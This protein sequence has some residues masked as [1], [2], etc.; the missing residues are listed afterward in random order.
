M[1]VGMVMVLRNWKLLPP[2]PVPGA[3]RE[4]G[5]TVLFER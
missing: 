2:K 3:T 1:P 4:N 5:F